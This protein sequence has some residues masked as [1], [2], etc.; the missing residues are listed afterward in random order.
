MH[1]PTATLAPPVS[2]SSSL[3][4]PPFASTPGGAV[5]PTPDPSLGP[6]LRLGQMTLRTP[7]TWKITGTS[8]SSGTTAWTVAGPSGLVQ[9]H[10]TTLNPHDP[11]DLLPLRSNPDSRYRLRQTSN[12]GHTV[13]IR[14]ITREGTRDSLM[15]DIGNPAIMRA[16]LQSW[17]HPPVLSVT[18]AATRLAALDKRYQNGGLHLSY[19][20]AAD[21]WLLAAGPAATVQETWDLFHTTDGGKTW[22][23]EQPSAGEGCNPFP[24]P[25]DCRFLDS[26]GQTTM[27]FWNARDGVIAQADMVAN[28]ATIFRTRDGGKSWMSNGIALPDHPNEVAL[29]QTSGGLAL[30]VAFNPHR[31]KETWISH[32]GGASWSQLG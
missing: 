1:R 26:S 20:T 12:Q 28:Q 32:D 23:L 25:P 16:V 27:R 2:G 19:G 5:T 17:T 6:P 22:H 10:S 11:L 24:M 8:R 18:G 21:G 30:T 3:T 4:P 14:L 13:T 15:A 7:P 31:P 29:Q 9:L